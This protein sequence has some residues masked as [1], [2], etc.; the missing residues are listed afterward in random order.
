M[1]CRMDSLTENCF[2]EDLFA[3]SEVGFGHGEDT[4]LS[5]RLASKGRLL[6]VSGA[7]FL[8]PCADP[9][10]AYATWAGKM[11]CGAGYSRRLLNDN[12]RWPDAPTLADR[13]AL[14]KSYTGNTVLNVFRALRSPKAHRFS[15]AWGYFCGAFKGVFLPPSHQRLTPQIDWQKDAEIALSQRVDITLKS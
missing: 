9:P 5:R 10:K 2:S 4:L 1:A 11:G 8:H 12:H 3:L 6:F 15:Y 7:R 14:W 13:F